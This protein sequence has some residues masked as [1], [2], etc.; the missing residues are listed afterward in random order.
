MRRVFIA[1]FLLS[2]F[3]SAQ[4][5]PFTFE[6]MMALKRVGEPAISPNGK[7]VAFSVTDVNLAENTRT[8]H[9]WVV[10]INGGDEKQI[11]EGAGE[12]RPQWSPDGKLLSYISSQDGESQVWAIDF[13]ADSGQPGTGEPKKLTNVATGA[14]GQ[15]WSPD[16]KWLL[17]TSGVYP[18]CKDIA[19]TAQ[20]D[21]ARAKSK[22]KAS[23]FRHLLYRH[24]NSYLGDKVTHIFVQPA[25]GSAPPRDLTLGAHDAP[26]FS[27]GGSDMYAFSPDSKEVAFTSN[28]DEVAATSTNNEIFIVPVEGG[29][30]K[31]IST[32]PGSD[33][34]PRYSPDGKYIAWLMQETPGYESD[35]FQLALYDRASEQMTYPTKTFDRWVGSFAWATDSKTIYFVAEDRGEAPIYSVSWQITQDSEKGYDISIRHTNVK[36]D[37][38]TTG[39]NDDL[40]VGLDGRMLVIT[41][42]SAGAPNEIY[43]LPPLQRTSTVTRPARVYDSVLT[44]D[45]VEGKPLTHL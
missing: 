15:I 1:L 18:D 13:D 30:P 34:T 2:S 10:S 3:V 38:I 39:H 35:R 17:F 22:V 40:T 19:C 29:T 26:P 21:E 23:E 5:R 8:P 36:I 25:D 32:S 24:W 14:D 11:T 4:K 43:S 28:I 44:T 27:L 16:G 6:D 33:S 9:L 20:R 37:S 7:W 12:S 31:K 41:R 42:M 45:A